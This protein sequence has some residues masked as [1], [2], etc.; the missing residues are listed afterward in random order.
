MAQSTNK[1]IKIIIPVIYIYQLV[2]DEIK[3]IQIK[4]V[5]LKAL[6]DNNKLHI[7]NEL[8]KTQLNLAAYYTF[9]Q[10]NYE[11]AVKY[12]TM[13][14]ENG[15]IKAIHKLGYHYQF[16]EKNYELMKKY[17]I[18][19]ID[20]GDT[21]A[22]VN[23]GCYYGNVEKNYDLMKTY[24]IMAAESDA[25]ACCNLGSYYEQNEKN[26]DL[27]KKYY[28]IAV[29]QGDPI[30]MTNLASYYCEI[31]KNY[32]LMMKC[33]MM[34]VDKKCILAM[35]KLA[36]YY[37][38]EK[39]IT[40]SNEYLQ[41]IIDTD[42]VIE[43]NYI[44]SEAMCGLADHYMVIKDYEL[45][46]KYY[47]MAIDYDNS[48]AMCNFACYYLGIEKNYEVMKKYY[49]MSVE[50]GNIHSM[51]QLGWYY[52]HIEKNIEEAKKYYIMSI[53]SNSNG[54]INNE[55]KTNEKCNCL[56]VVVEILKQ[57]TTQQE[58]SDLHAKYG[59]FAS[60]FTSDVMQ[61]APSKS[62]E[63]TDSVQ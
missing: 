47:M 6:Y 26:Y 37:F 58:K 27:M 39:N 51:L 45:M 4:P 56:Q 3:Y 33:L 12:L 8:D 32:D 19:A 54:N 43:Y 13:S 35:Y 44:K 29:E 63:P 49:M 25:A 16:I 59:I 14:I 40:K 50:K 2:N 15:N 21:A 42:D 30:S 31:E 28:M 20:K 17:Y 52:Q 5:D 24:Y 48:R 7:P 46:K 60:C 53:T 22:M 1:D 61:T 38:N 18:M 34:A 23:L 62:T 11:E 9:V 10:K 57:I 36:S 55:H 41:M